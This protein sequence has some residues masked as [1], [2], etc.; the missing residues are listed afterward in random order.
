MCAKPYV[1]VAQFIFTGCPIAIC[2]TG[3][4]RPLI[5]ESILVFIVIY[6]QR[7]LHE[8]V[9]FDQTKSGTLAQPGKSK[10]NQA[11]ERFHIFPDVGDAFL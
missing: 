11:R 9:L 5:C 2:A 7:I 6:H 4:S 10:I 1:Q 3:N 8:F